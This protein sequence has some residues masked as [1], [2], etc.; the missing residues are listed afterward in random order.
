MLQNLWMLGSFRNVMKLAVQIRNIFKKNKNS[1]ISTP[2]GN[3]IALK[4]VTGI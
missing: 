4:Y 3:D 1:V 2:D